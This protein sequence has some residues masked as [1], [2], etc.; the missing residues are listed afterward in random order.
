V[1]SSKE[2]CILISKIIF[3]GSETSLLQVVDKDKVSVPATEHCH[4]NGRL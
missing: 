1:N 2:S 4:S 3:P